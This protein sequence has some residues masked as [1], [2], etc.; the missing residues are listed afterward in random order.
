M[1][2]IGSYGSLR[3]GFWN[4]IRFGLGEPILTTT[5]K[6][7]MFMNAALGYPWLIDEKDAN[8]P[9]E[10]IKEYPM[11]VYEINEDLYE[12][13]NSME[14]NSGYKTVEKEIEGYP[15][16]IWFIDIDQIKPQKEQWIPDYQPTLD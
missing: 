9:K 3:K 4:H 11:E 13:I 5:I 14:I 2:R 16:T 6:G 1:K 15:T 7:A 10:L 8:F 12:R